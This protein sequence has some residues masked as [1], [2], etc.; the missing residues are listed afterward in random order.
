MAQTTLAATYG[1]IANVLR[2]AQ[3]VAI[4]VENAPD[5]RKRLRTFSGQEVA[6]LLGLKLQEIAAYTRS[7]DHQSRLPRNRLDFNDIIALR[8]SLRDS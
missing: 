8:K 2:A 3:R 7:P 6:L 4:E 1:R 5:K